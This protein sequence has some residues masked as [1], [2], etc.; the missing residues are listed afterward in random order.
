MNVLDLFCGAGGF[1]SGF[2]KAGFNIVLA[3][4]FD[5]EIA[6][7]YKK[8]HKDTKLI[9]GDIRDNIDQIC[10]YALKKNTDI[11]IG[12]P[13]CQGF[14]MAGARIRKEKSYK[15]ID[16]E[17][18]YLF[19]YYLSII[20][21]VKPKF[22]IMENV[23]GLLSMKN[24]EILSEIEKNLKSIKSKKNMNYYTYKFV[25][26]S[27][28]L[29]VPQSRKRLFILGSEIKLDIKK[30]ISKKYEE[31]V[32]NGLIL[33]T[34]IEDAISD[35]NWLESGEGCFEQNYK[36]EPKS[37]YQ[38]L[39]RKNSTNLYNHQ[40]TKH[41]DI[42]INRIKE[43]KPGDSRINLAE[44]SKIKS[45]HSGAYGRMSWNKKSK[46]IITRFDTPSSGE[47]THPER[48]RTIT[49][50]EAARLQSFDDDYIF[51]GTKSSIIKQIGNAVPPLV[52]YFLANVIKELLEND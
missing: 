52:S 32:E 42:A 46:T 11:I 35:L 19:K 2:E 37:K 27:S 49:P 8:N 50:R 38:K 29:G 1:S 33:N 9:V 48:N 47:Y 13:P 21:K 44:S 51:Y 16:D 12:G 24:G 40:A 6:R 28:Y 10:E 3:N 5:P 20:Q 43:L 39:R 45:V 26:D 18:N 7:T 31:F 17:R 14:S 34:T 30:V 4:E 15:F 23:P 25:L 41:S 22:F 36:Y